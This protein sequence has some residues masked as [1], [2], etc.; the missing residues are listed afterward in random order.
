[1]HMHTHTHIGTQAGLGLAGDVAETGPGQEPLP[2]TAVLELGLVSGVN[3]AELAS[4][5]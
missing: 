2:R 1:M 5:R 4:P 3:P